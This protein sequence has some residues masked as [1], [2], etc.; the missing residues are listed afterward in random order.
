[1]ATFAAAQRHREPT[2]PTD[3]AAFFQEHGWT[4][5]PRLVQWM[6]TQSCPLHCPHCLSNAAPHNTQ[7]SSL[8]LAT[9]LIEQ[10]SALGVEELLLTG[11]EPLAHPHLSTIIKLLFARRVRWSLNTAAMPTPAQQRALESWPP[12]FVAVSLD[13]P[14]SVHDAFRGRGA[15]EQ[16]INSL[17]Y[18]SALIPGRVAAG[19]TVTTANF[20]QL[21]ATFGLVLESGATEW[22]LHLLVP[23]GRAQE[24]PDLF[25]SRQQLKHLLEFAAAKRNH[26]PVT[27]A[28]EIGYCGYW[29]PLVREARFFCGAGKLQCVVL[30][31]G[32]VMPCTTWDRSASAGNLHTRPLAE[33]W[34]TG[35]AD[36]RAWEPAGRCGACAYA[37]ACQGGCWL[38]RRHGTECYREVWHMPQALTTAGTAVCIGLA[39]VSC[40]R[41]DKVLSPPPVIAQPAS[42]PSPAAITKPDMREMEVLQSTIIQWYAA[43][44]RGH[45]VSPW[46]KVEATL[47]TTLPDDLGSH[48]FLRYIH[49]QSA[50]ELPALVEEIETALQTKQRSLC[51][52]GLAWRALTERCLEGPPATQRTATD[53]AALRQ[54]L[55]ALETTAAAWRKEIFEKKLDPFLRQPND[56]RQFFLSKAGPMA[57]EVVAHGLAVKRGWASPPDYLAKETPPAITEA[58]VAAHPYA[59]PMKLPLAKDGGLF[60]LRDG[61]RQ[62]TDGWLKI[63]D[64]LLV[65][66]PTTVT[67]STGKVALD[68]ALPAGTE[69]AYGD[70]LRLAYEQHKAALETLAADIIRGRRERPSP[71]LLPALTEMS[72]R[73]HVSPARWMLIDLYLF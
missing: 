17:A 51:L 9:S 31:D 64:L 67:L 3:E 45:R 20:R 58:F 29:E 5:S 35:F 42:Q 34:A 27:M 49:G 6:V 54:G 62:R 56:Y 63:F 12:Y 14:P 44:T 50:K 43:Q 25:L 32:N 68:V 61:Q 55:A 21:P 16:A 36:L 65:P 71:L 48:F 73:A 24:R 33:I 13:G 70:V 47:K 41:T 8:E 60:V 39:T 11:G 22:G 4:R 10:A 26:F 19:T 2:G 1:M 7:H 66:D 38:Q 23:E 46:D 52:I 72:R 28:D 18:F 57:H 15:F 30:P 40:T 37:P 59:D 69:L 53:A